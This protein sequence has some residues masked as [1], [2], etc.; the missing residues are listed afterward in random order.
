MEEKVAAMIQQKRGLAARIV[1]SGEQWLTEL[2]T[3]E[4]RELFTLESGAVVE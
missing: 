4:L 3:V 1:G 2:S